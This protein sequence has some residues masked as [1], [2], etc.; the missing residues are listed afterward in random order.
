MPSPQNVDS[1]VQ[2]RRMFIN[3]RPHRTYRAALVS[4]L[5][6]LHSSRAHHRLALISHSLQMSIRPQS[7]QESADLSKRCCRHGDQRRPGVGTTTR[8]NHVAHRGHSPPLTD[9]LSP[10]CRAIFLTK[11]VATFSEDLIDGSL[12]PD[13]Y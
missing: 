12:G 1:Q 11:F 10:F 4:W 8:L 13:S 7:F 2:E 3:V 5:L 6:Y 9:C